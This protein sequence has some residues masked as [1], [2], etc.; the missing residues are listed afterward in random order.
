MGLNSAPPADRHPRFRLVA[1][2]VAVLSGLCGVGVIAAQAVGQ[3]DDSLISHWLVASLNLLL[4]PAAFGL[5]W[6][7]G[8]GLSTSISTVAGVGSLALWATHQ[9]TRPL[10]HLEAIWT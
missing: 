3:G 10:P 6:A 7:L 1:G 2:I 4:L 8:R 9:V 5:W